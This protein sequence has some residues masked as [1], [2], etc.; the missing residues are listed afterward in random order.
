MLFHSRGL[1]IRN[2]PQ[3]GLLTLTLVALTQCVWSSLSVGVDEALC[4]WGSIFVDKILVKRI[5]YKNKQTNKLSYLS[6]YPFPRNVPGALLKWKNQF[7]IFYLQ[8]SPLP[9]LHFYM[10]KNMWSLLYHD[11]F[12]FFEFVWRFNEI[13][14]STKWNFCFIRDWFYSTLSS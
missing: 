2:L 1:N 6:G 7:V 9:L 12:G 8:K 4:R 11:F 14:F 13:C 10:F 5:F 3:C